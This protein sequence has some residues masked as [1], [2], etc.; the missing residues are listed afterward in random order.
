MIE[1]NLILHNTPHAFGQPSPDHS[2][3]VHPDRVGILLKQY[4]FATMAVPLH[5]IFA[6]FYREQFVEITEY[7]DSQAIYKC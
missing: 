7:K 5:E 6:S 1:T 3:V 4:N 2:T